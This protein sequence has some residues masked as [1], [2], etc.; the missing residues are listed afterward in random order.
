MSRKKLI[1]I[2]CLDVFAVLAIGFLLVR[3]VLTKPH[4]KSLEL[5]QYANYTSTISK[6]DCYLCGN[7]PN[8]TIAPYLGQ[9]NLGLINLNTFDC[10]SFDVNRYSESNELLETLIKYPVRRGSQ[11]DENTGTT[12]DYDFN[13]NKGYI[14]VKLDFNDNSDLQIDRI[15][16]FLCSDCLRCVM[17]GYWSSERYL[18]IAL[19]DFK[20]AKIKP[21]GAYSAGLPLSDYYASVNYNS[22]YD[23]ID[24]FAF[25][26]PDR[27]SEYG[28]NPNLSVT[29]EIMQYCDKNDFA[30][31]LNDEVKEFLSDFEEIQGISCGDESV[32]FRDEP[33]IGDKEL[34][35]NKDG[36]YSIFDLDR[37]R[38]ESKKAS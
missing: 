18:D 22:E 26:C 32:L 25:Y 34:T 21:I 29:E 33:I 12:L 20:N 36:T 1:C 27:Y 35:I 24:I 19:I 17:D 3:L 5:D 4:E 8:S 15:Q 38:E 16:T 11:G 14:N 31:T 13:A 37:L 6:S 10:L 23:Y 7:N 30:F 9:S 28:Y 2:C